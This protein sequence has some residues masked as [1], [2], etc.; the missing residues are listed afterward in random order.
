M[1]CLLESLHC[2]RR[3]YP[4]PWTSQVLPD[5]TGAPRVRNTVLWW[6]HFNGFQMLL[7]L[8][9]LNLILL[10]PSSVPVLDSSLCSPLAPDFTT[11]RKTVL[12]LNPSSVPHVSPLPTSLIRSPSLLISISQLR[13]VCF[14]FLL[15]ASWCS[16]Q[17]ITVRTGNSV[18][19]HFLTYCFC[20]SVGGRIAMNGLLWGGPVPEHA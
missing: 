1:H 2:R 13:S 20:P 9:L 19:L 7:P 4:A 14:L 18:P 3:S 11:H 5:S 16:S 6:G 12:V 8:V 10:L 15:P 17:E